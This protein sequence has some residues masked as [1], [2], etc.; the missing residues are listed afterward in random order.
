MS[1]LTPKKL[2]QEAVSKRFLEIIL[3][4]SLLKYV[5][6]NYTLQFADPTADT[7]LLKKQHLEHLL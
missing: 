1:S 2:K 7:P 5:P 4:W 6:M 3:I